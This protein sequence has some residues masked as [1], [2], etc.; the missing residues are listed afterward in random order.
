VL[1]SIHT[2]THLFLG[3][4]LPLLHTFL[5]FF[6]QDG[7]PPPPPPPPMVAEIQPPPPSPSLHCSSFQQGGP[8]PQ[9]PARI[10]RQ[11]PALVWVKGLLIS[12]QVA[13]LGCDWGCD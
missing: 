1:C 6:M 5:H 7:G 13:W 2:Q 11:E 8:P 12:R 3:H 4:G 10:G 9:L